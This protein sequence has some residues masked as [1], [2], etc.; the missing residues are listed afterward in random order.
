ME[1]TE[2]FAGDARRRRGARLVAVTTTVATAV[3]LWAV[4]VGL[5]MDLRSPAFGEY[6]TAAVGA[7][8]VAFVSAL[9]GIAAWGLLAVLERLSSRRARRA[10]LVIA[11]IA[12]VAS[13]GGPMSGTGIT[14]ANRMELMGLHL[15]VGA[16]L[17]PLLYRT[18]PKHSASSRGDR[19]EQH[20]T[21]GA[22]RG[23]AA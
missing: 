9:A 8:N 2:V 1:M 4:Y 13:L 21:E 12:L 3:G 18:S 23:V 15:A 5:G 22:T 20:R 14:S 10:W 6:G 17:I 16:V 7:G 11:V 19:D